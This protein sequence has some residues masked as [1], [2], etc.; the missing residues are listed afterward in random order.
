[1]RRRLCEA[2]RVATAPRAPFVRL[3]TNDRD[4]NQLFVAHPGFSISAPVACAAHSRTRI[5]HAN[6]CSPVLLRLCYFTLPFPTRLRL[7]TLLPHL[8]SSPAPSASCAFTASRLQEPRIILVTRKNIKVRSKLSRIA[9]SSHTLYKQGYDLPVTVVVD[10]HGPTEMEL[11]LGEQSFSLSMDSQR[12]RDLAVLCIRMFA[13][14]NCPAHDSDSDDDSGHDGGESSDGASESHKSGAS[15]SKSGGPIGF[16][17][18]ASRGSEAR[19]PP[20]IAELVDEAD[21]ELKK[22]TWSDDEAE[23][24]EFKPA[25]TVSIR[26]KEDAI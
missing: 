10:Q 21:E 26:S 9:T 20:P 2:R 16:S 7:Y 23:A 19:L 17:S 13:G 12:S 4:S 15:E 5:G 18:G 1:M 25:I 24:D 22:V 11:K 8:S 14:P 3:Q 6:T